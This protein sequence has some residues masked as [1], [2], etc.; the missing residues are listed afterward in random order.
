MKTREEGCLVAQ[1]LK[2]VYEETGN[3]VIYT[4]HITTGPE[5]RA[6]SSAL[7]EDSAAGR[8]DHA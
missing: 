4:P 3:R 1:R 8:K 5:I 7:Q 2:Q 6:A